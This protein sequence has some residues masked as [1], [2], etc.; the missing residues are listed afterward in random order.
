[1]EKTSALGQLETFPA[2]TEMS[3]AG[4]RPDVIRT[5]TD[6]G[7][8]MLPVGGRADDIGAQPF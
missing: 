5:K 2:L 7:Q 4:G 1:M 6:I 8:R 3:D